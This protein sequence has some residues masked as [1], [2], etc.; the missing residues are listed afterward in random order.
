MQ[1]HAAFCFAPRRGPLPLC[2]P[3]ACCSCNEGQRVWLISLLACEWFL[4]L[5]ALRV[6]CSGAAGVGRVLPLVGAGPPTAAV[7][8]AALFHRYVLLVGSSTNSLR[9]TQSVRPLA[10]HGLIITN[11]NACGLPRR[12]M[13]AVSRSPLRPPQP[14]LSIP[15]PSSS[16]VP[17]ATSPDIALL[18]H[19]PLAPLS[20][21]N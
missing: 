11:S 6:G 9:H 2:W 13:L 14:P 17:S 21:C 8:F 4:I 18:P 3:S 16:L 5:K 7:A 12:L 10:Y 19:S 20:G 15:F 1:V